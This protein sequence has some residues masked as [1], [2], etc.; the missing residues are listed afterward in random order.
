MHRVSQTLLLISLLLGLLAACGKSADSAPQHDKDAA[1]SATIET[2]TEQITTEQLVI[3]QNNFAFNIYRETAG[4]QGNYLISPVSIHTALTMAADGARGNTAAQMMQALSLP[5]GVDPHAAYQQLFSDLQSSAQR[6]GSSGGGVEL[7]LVNNLWLQ[8]D[9]QLQEAFLTNLATNYGAGATPLDFAGAPEP[10]R[11]HINEAIEQTTEDRITDLLPPGSVT[12]LTRLVLTNAVYFKG[13]W[14]EPFET[15]ATH[16][17]DFHVSADQTVQAEM[18]NGSIETA[19]GSGDGYQIAA[20]NY[21]GSNLAMLLLLPDDLA[22]TEA[23][24]DATTLQAMTTSMT[25]HRVTLTLPR[26][27][28]TYDKTLNTPLKSLG[29]TDAFE[30]GVADLSGIDGVTGNRELAI[31]SVLHKAFIDVNEAGTEAAAATAVLIGTTSMPPQATLTLDRPFLYMIWDRGTG[32]V[33][34]LGRVSDP[35]Q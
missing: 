1:N 32:A 11:K 6:P 29:M 30:S 31:T 18:M 33:L 22:A 5:T 7:R 17:G 9:A 28:Y 23:T 13:A 15:E 12:E 10:S 16:S 25:R 26:W 35:T 4:E 34:F 21:D 8:Q 3:A 27:S 14:R 19:F 2:T 20:L 24:L